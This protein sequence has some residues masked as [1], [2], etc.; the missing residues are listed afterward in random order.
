MLP[1][2]RMKFKTEPLAAP[3]RRPSTRLL[4]GAWLL[5]CLIWGSTWGAIKI[6]LSDLPPFTFAGVRF[7]LAATILFGVAALRGRS[8]W[9]RPGEW[10]FLVVTGTLAF[11]VNYAGLFWGEQHI[12]SGQAAVLQATI[13]GFGLFF[14]HA[15]LPGERLSA[16]RVIGALAGLVGVGVIFLHELHASGKMALWGSAAVVLGAAS[17]S[18]SNVLVKA[19]AGTSTRSCWRAGRW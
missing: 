5:L 18:W 13:P 19:R 1:Y 14:A 2:R 11:T 12:P 9:P 3:E 10:R 15:Y 7:V 16:A 4:V 17:V 6:G 8:L